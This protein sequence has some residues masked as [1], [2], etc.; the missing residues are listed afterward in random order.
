MSSNTAIEKLYSTLEPIVGSSE[1][2]EAIST[3]VYI[4]LSEIQDEGFKISE[5]LLEEKLNKH[6]EDYIEASQN[7]VA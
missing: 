4:V 2:K 3:I 1:A 6:V 7:R 5:I